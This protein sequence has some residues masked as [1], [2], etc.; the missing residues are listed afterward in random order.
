MNYAV[1]VIQVIEVDPG[2][3]LD[4]CAFCDEPTRMAVCIAG[5][6]YAWQQ[7]QKCRSYYNPGVIFR[8]ENDD[9]VITT[10]D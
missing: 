3:T 6:M 4:Y 2:E 1:M 5:P 10:P 7:C 9:S 8:G